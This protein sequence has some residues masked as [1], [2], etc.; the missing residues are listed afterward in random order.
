[1]KKIT[2]IITAI[3]ILAPLVLLMSGCGNSEELSGNASENNSTSEYSSEQSTQTTTEKEP[4]IIPEKQQPD[5]EPTFLICPDGEPLY[6]SEI[7][8][9]CSYKRDN[10][11][12]LVP[13]EEGSLENFTAARCDG[14]VY[15]YVPER[16]YNFV[17]NPELFDF[18]TTN[19]EY[20][21]Y[22]GK[23][24]PNI[25]EF[26]RIREGDKFGTLTVSRACSYFSGEYRDLSDEEK[27]LPGAYYVGGCLELEGEIELT[28]YMLV[29]VDTLYDSAGD[30]YFFPDGESSTKIP[31]I[32]D[33]WDRENH[34]LYEEYNSSF[35][36]YYGSYFGLGNM[37]DYDID[38]YGLRP[39]DDFVKVRVTLGDIS[40]DTHDM[41]YR[42]S[43]VSLKSLERLY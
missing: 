35:Y 1:M 27:T 33:H 2:A 24:Y 11:I 38:F 19:R 21:Y 23:E 39:G 31:Y 25:T 17:D 36:G 32:A 29:E 12:E 5:G 41:L 6:T 14:F 10:H 28:G 34:M 26:T 22:K 9:F 18:K 15:G 42:F 4:E 16:S 40:Y 37:N 3:L 8:Q 13:D 20:R 7:T 30:L 43:K